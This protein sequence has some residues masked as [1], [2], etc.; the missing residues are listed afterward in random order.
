[1]RVVSVAKKYL[2]LDVRYRAMSYFCAI[3]L[4][5]YIAAILPP[6][7]S[8]YFV[9]KHNILN[10]YG[11]K[12]GWF[13]TSILLIP[14]MWWTSSLHYESMSKAFCALSRYAIATFLW[15]FCTGIFMHV[16]QQTSGCSDSYECNG[17]DQCCTGKRATGFDISG[18]T[19]LLLY[20]ILIINEEVSSF[21]NWPKAPRTTPM[22]I[23]NVGEYNAYKKTTKYIRYLFVGLFCLHL[24][25]D[26]QLVITVL[27]YHEL[28]HKVFAA[29]IAVLCWAST[30]R[31]LF[32]LAS[33]APIKRHMKCS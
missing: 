4:L 26:L 27:F 15:Y 3:V 16:E 13:W 18:H 1:M 8:S 21:R 5:S 19:F 32:P 31:L 10:Q 20:S 11:T 14:F 22:H 12:L 33:I 9:Q 17:S 24:F 28:L 29:A 7:K 2:F 23:P 6:S 25:W 30:Y